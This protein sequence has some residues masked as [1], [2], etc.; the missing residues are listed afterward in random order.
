M[1]FSKQSSKCLSWIRHTEV[2]SDAFGTE[3]CGDL[4]GKVSRDLLG[5]CRMDVRDK[6]H[7]IIL[8]YQLVFEF[9][10]LKF[11]FNLCVSVSDLCIFAFN[12]DIT[13]NSEPIFLQGYRSS[14]G[15]R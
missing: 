13:E 14:V 6:C 8:I 9:L 2:I 15:F 4:H 3:W 7:Q 12:S 10:L 11:L 5:S 1:G